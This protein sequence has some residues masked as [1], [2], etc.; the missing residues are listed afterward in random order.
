MLRLAF[1]EEVIYQ[2]HKYI[3]EQ[4]SEDLE[5]IVIKS[6]KRYHEYYGLGEYPGSPLEMARGSDDPG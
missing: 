4:D 3:Y 1:A 6:I 5:E 2:L